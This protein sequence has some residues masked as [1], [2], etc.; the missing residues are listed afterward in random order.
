MDNFSSFA[1]SLDKINK[2]IDRVKSEKTTEYGIRIAHFNCLVH[3][4]QVIDGLTP[5]EISR[6]CSVDKAFVSRITS[7]L[8]KGD[9]IQTNKIFLRLPEIPV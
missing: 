4:D 1:L 2:G 3:I 9:F 8:I 7:D 5:T 6:V